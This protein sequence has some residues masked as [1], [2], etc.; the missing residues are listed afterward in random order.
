M[1]FADLPG[2]HPERGV[3]STDETCG[4]VVHLQDLGDFPC[5][6][7]HDDDGGHDG[8]CITQPELDGLWPA[9]DFG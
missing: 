4:V 7:E 9:R 2:L 6:I 3:V 8:D 1:Q 5:V